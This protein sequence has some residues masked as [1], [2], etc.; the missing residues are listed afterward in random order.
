MKDEIFLIALFLRNA[1]LEVEFYRYYDP[2]TCGFDAP[3]A[4]EDLVVHAHF[5]THEIQGCV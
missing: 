1:G 3:V 5:C 2:K 4:Y